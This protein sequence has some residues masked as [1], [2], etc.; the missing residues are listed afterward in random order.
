MWNVSPTHAITK[1]HIMMTNLEIMIT[2]MAWPT[3]S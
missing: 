3:E 1:D 2:A